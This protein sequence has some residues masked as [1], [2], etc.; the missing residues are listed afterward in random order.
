MIRRMV[1]GLVC[2]LAF[3]ALG[4]A[5]AQSVNTNRWLR[6]FD[7]LRN[8]IARN[9]A[10]IDEAI[11]RQGLNPV[12]MSNVTIRSIRAAQTDDEARRALQVFVASFGDP[13]LK[14]A[15]PRSR[16]IE[17]GSDEA[18]AMT[19]NATQVCKA[20]NYKAYDPE[21]FGMG[22]LKDYTFNV[23]VSQNNVFGAGIIESGSRGVGYL[24]VPSF[25]TEDYYSACLRA[26]TNRQNATDELC[27]ATCLRDMTDRV[28][29]NMLIDDFARH[30]E[31]LA[32]RRVG[33]LV[34]DLTGTRGDGEWAEA[35][36]VLL[37]GER[38]TCPAVDVPRTRAWR[39]RFSNMRRTLGRAEVDERAV[40]LIEQSRERVRALADETRATCRRPENMWTDTGFDRDACGGLISNATTS[41]GLY[42]QLE[43]LTLGDSSASRLMYNP[44]YFSIA[45]SPQPTKLF[46]VTDEDTFGSAELL[47]IMLQDGGAAEIVGQTTAGAGCRTFD[48]DD[49]RVILRR[50]GLELTIP[51][52]RLT[53]ADGTN[54]ARGVSPDNSVSW[55]GES[56]SDAA[57]T[58][59]Y[60]AVLP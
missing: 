19:S 3:A 46:V 8:E 22:V 59:I 23:I 25:R 26:W 21:P 17:L 34:V 54:A 28:I 55:S 53:R 5:F 36:A 15:P 24:R 44:G 60:D 14:L 31:A 41:C 42:S 1:A 45:D 40:T 51:N 4:E 30:V 32:E 11:S 29:P 50:S 43:G 49:S 47:S 35:I 52:C 56:D 20:L 33:T 9:Y 37:A 57:R 13:R 39:D 16:P 38:A 48:G 12:A 7:Q 58:A 6:D 10:D 2:G 18:L 27:D